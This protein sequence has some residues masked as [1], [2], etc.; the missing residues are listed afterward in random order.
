MEPFATTFPVGDDVIGTTHVAAWVYPPLSPSAFLPVIWGFF[1]PGSTYSGRGYYDLQVP[2]VAEDSYSMARFLAQRGIGIITFDHLGTG[3]STCAVSGEMLTWHRTALLYAQIV[4]QLRERLKHGTLC[5][6]Y[7]PIELERLFLWGA[8]HSLGGFVLTELEATCHCFDAVAFL[9]W[10]QGP[11][12][13]RLR[14]QDPALR[15]VMSEQNG[16]MFL[17]DR[18]LLHWFLYGDPS[19]VTTQVIATDAANAVA[20]PAGLFRELITGNDEQ[21]SRI[22]CPIYLSFG[23]DIDM[24]EQPRHEPTYYRASQ[25]ITCFLLSKAAHCANFSPYRQTLWEHLTAWVQTRA[26][27]GIPVLTSSTLEE[28]L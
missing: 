8:G 18:S 9:G 20:V 13:P 26:K 24:C 5:A 3:A 1:L 17:N 7:A 28:R 11:R 4:T 22:D 27:M 12:H 10:A 15:K 23:Q 16:Y 21:A 25:D 2:G 19:T 14:A 6:G